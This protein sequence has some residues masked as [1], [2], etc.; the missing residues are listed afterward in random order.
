MATLSRSFKE[1]GHKESVK[2]R[3]K[4]TSGSRGGASGSL[5][6]QRVTFLFDASGSMSCGVANTHQTRLAAV[7][8]AGKQV[9][10]RM[11]DDDTL[12]VNLFADR[13]VT[14]ANGIPKDQYDA[15]AVARSSGVAGV[16]T[17]M[18][19]ALWA[20]TEESRRN[21]DVLHQVV[22][23]TDGAATDGHLPIKKTVV[24]WLETTPPHLKI[25][26]ITSEINPSDKTV[27]ANLRAPFVRVIE[28]H[29]NFNGA[30]LTRA[31]GDVSTRVKQSYSV[32]SAHLTKKSHNST[33][34][35]SHKVEV[36][37]N[38]Y[39]FL[40]DMA[41]IHPSSAPLAMKLG[42]ELTQQAIANT[43]VSPFTPPANAS[44][45]IGGGQQRRLAA[46][47]EVTDRRPRPASSRALSQQSTRERKWVV[48][49]DRAGYAIMQAKHLQL[50]AKY[51]VSLRIPSKP[52]NMSRPIRQEWIIVGEDAGSIQAAY[53]ELD[54]IVG[55]VK[56]RPRA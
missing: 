6:T 56:G 28:I 3:E 33:Y 18:W 27:L 48:M 35:E 34:E 38:A 46:N 7:S 26:F 5:G 44:R 22:V 31:F 12:T 55:V 51:N 17:A 19:A 23:F 13:V 15:T 36:D 37:P 47:A 45:V 9:I 30:D 16:Y 49:S 14:I 40:V 29:Q 21:P 2:V 42:L 11:N 20:S 39:K 8:E 54:R 53:E 41:R 43:A 50:E 4:K 52:S 25:Y 32:Y 24:D 10:N 1:S